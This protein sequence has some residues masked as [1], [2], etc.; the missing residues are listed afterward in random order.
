M[1][2]VQVD[3]PCDELSNLLYCLARPLIDEGLRIGLRV[4]RR[5]QILHS[6]QVVLPTFTARFDQVQEDQ[7]ENAG[8]RTILLGSFP[9]AKRT[10]QRF[11]GLIF[12]DQG[13]AIRIDE[14]G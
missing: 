4:C 5:D 1:D 11:H 8:H 7:Q 3:M 6:F 10:R 13:V 9:V 2:D 14:P 12:E